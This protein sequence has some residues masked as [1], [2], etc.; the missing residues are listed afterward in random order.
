MSTIGITDDDAPIT[1]PPI[2]GVEHEIDF[3][4]GAVLP[5]QPAYRMS[6]RDTDILQE[7][8]DKLLNDGLI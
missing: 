8:M 2:R 6:P 3:L 5:N 7:Y 4:P 1:L